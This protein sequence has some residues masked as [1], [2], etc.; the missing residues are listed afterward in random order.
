LL[1]SLALPSLLIV[2]PSASS[3]LPAFIIPQNS[4]YNPKIRQLLNSYYSSRITD[5]VIF[6]TNHEDVGP[7]LIDCLDPVFNDLVSR[8]HS[9]VNT[10]T[11]VETVYP[12][13]RIHGYILRSRHN[14]SSLIDQVRP[15]YAQFN[16]ATTLYLASVDFAHYLNEAQSL[17]NDSQTL[18][19]LRDKNYSQISELTSNHTDCPDCLIAFVE[20]FGSNLEVVDHIYQSGTSYFTMTF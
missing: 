7:L 17:Q 9:F 2:R 20:L 11:V 14:P 16:P 5:V 6:G 15:I 13:A 19:L 12:Q 4:T 3:R 18:Q 1:S 8:E 10:K